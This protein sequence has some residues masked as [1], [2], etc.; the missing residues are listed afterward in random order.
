MDFVIISTAQ[1][2]GLSGG[3]TTS[4][5]G[6]TPWRCYPWP[7]NKDSTSCSSSNQISTRCMKTQLP[8]MRWICFVRDG[9]Y[10]M[11]LD[12]TF[13]L[14]CLYHQ[15]TNFLLCCGSLFQRHWNWWWRGSSVSA[16]TAQW[17]L[18]NLQKKLQG[19]KSLFGKIVEVPK[20]NILNMLRG[21]FRYCY[22]QTWRGL[23]KL[24]TGD[25]R[26]PCK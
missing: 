23:G 4:V 18:F 1:S 11:R 9:K 14:K 3:Q 15:F 25:W 8:S 24:M 17:G 19:L 16:R 13:M 7:M 5:A 2:N 10:R 20:I 21:L 6:Q 22:W 12:F 26:A